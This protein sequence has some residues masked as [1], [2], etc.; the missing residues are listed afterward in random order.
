MKT[1]PYCAEEVQDAAIVCKHCGRELAPHEVAELSQSMSA[2][3]PEPAE[4]P[5]PLA[6]AE[7]SQSEVPPQL[8]E[9]PSV[10]WYR[11]TW[12]YVIWFIFLT[13]VWSILKLTDD[14]ARTY[15]KV[16]AGILLSWPA[17]L[18]VLYLLIGASTGVSAVADAAKTAVYDQAGRQVTPSPMPIVAADPTSTPRLQPV[19]TVPVGTV[20]GHPISYFA[21]LEGRQVGVLL[22]TIYPESYA[23]SFVH[24][25]EAFDEAEK[26]VCEVSALYGLG[27][28]V[29]K[30]LLDEAYQNGIAST[31][32]ED[33]VHFVLQAGSY[34]CPEATETESGLPV[35]RLA[36]Y[37]CVSGVGETRARIELEI[38][39][40]SRDG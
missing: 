14:R 6:Q 27:C 26:F 35:M 24:S 38:I 4:P 30:S 10:P 15:T 2:P 1:C 31:K 21:E 39:R 3:K 12:A 11:Q 28:Q 18:L 17:C 36:G 19:S 13:L 34:E 7:L 33:F 16:L 40:D 20:L 23:A 29:A 9:E 22:V 25:V 32:L 37:G 8:S 5:E